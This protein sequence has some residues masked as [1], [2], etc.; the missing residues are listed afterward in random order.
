MKPDFDK[1]AETRGVDPLLVQ[2]YY[3]TLPHI[4]GVKRD[5]P[6]IIAIQLPTALRLAE[7]KENEVLADQ[8]ARAFLTGDQREAHQY[9]LPTEETFATTLLKMPED[10]QETVRKS[11]IEHVEMMCLHAHLPRVSI[12]FEGNNA[13]IDP[14][15]NEDKQTLRTLFK[16]RQPIIDAAFEEQRRALERHPVPYKP[17]W[18]QNN[19][20]WEKA[21]DLSELTPTQ[22]IQLQIYREALG[23]HKE[24]LSVAHK[25]IEEAAQQ[26]EKKP[27]NWVLLGGFDFDN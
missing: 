19:P 14:L 6:K 8:F 18:L 5:D 16:E 26:W 21:E 15:C 11:I 27:V 12:G 3:Q 20:E 24:A 9:Y 23:H 17:K 13:I 7:R 10:R 1:V 22:R 4:K 2:E 25:K